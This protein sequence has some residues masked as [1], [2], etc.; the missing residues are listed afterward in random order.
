MKV[1][2]MKCL[3]LLSLS[4]PAWGYN[5]TQDFKNGFYWASLPIKILVEDTNTSRKQLLVQLA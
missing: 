5:L 1:M 3:L 4:L 2:W